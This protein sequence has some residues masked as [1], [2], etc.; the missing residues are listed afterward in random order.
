MIND[1][2]SPNSSSS[3]LIILVSLLA[4]LLI[5]GLLVFLIV[6]HLRR[7]S[8]DWSEGIEFDT[9]RED[10]SENQFTLDSV[11]ETGWISQCPPEFGSG[12]GD[13][14]GETANMWL[15]SEHL[16]AEQY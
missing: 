4:L 12:A 10:H 6:M 3:L 2:S 1:A 9:E 13:G 15:W 8:T 7:K 11:E 5:V 14:D 16:A